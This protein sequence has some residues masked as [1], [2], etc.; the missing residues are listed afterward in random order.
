PAGSVAKLKL[1]NQNTSGGNDH[2]VY[3]NNFIV[4]T[5]VDNAD[6]YSGDYAGQDKGD[7]AIGSGN[8]GSSYTTPTLSVGDSGAQYEVLVYSCGGAVLSS[9]A[10]LTVS[11]AATVNAGAD[12]TV[13]ASSPDVTLAGS[14]GGG[15]SSATWSG[16]AGR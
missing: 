7:V 10:T 6:N 8:G 1:F 14:F 15:A 13:C 2:N 4:G 11:P 16:G 12:Q 9:T 5:S 3:W